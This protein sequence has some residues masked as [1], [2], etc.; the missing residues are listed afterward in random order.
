MTE[1]HRQMSV[2]MMPDYRVDNPYQT[3]LADSL[4]KQLISVDFCHGYRR[5]FPIY[6]Q[7][8]I[9]RESVLH[10]HW[11]NPYL[12][13]ENV[14]VKLIYCLKFLVDIAL[15]KA[16]KT[17]IV[18]TVHNLVSHNAKFPRLEK[19]TK[20]FFLKSVDHVI[21][22]SEAAKESVVQAYE[23]NDEKISVVPH[24]HYRDVY[25]PAIAQAEA[26]EQ[27]GLSPNGLLFLNFGMLRPY[28]GVEKLLEIWCS[29]HQLLAEA[30]LL[31]AG[32]ALDSDYG[33]ELAEQAACAKNIRLNDEFVDNEKIHLYFSAADI[34]AL[35]FNQILTSGSLLLAMSYGKPIIAPRS[36]SIEETLRG[37]TD[38]LYSPEDSS[39]LLR[40]IQDSIG[41]DLALL[42]Q[43]V[44]IACDRLNWQDIAS[45]TKA[46]YRPE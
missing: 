7:W 2:L 23:L 24:G 37:A 20:Q 30:Q 11:L 26:R 15:I 41:R 42:S 19:W 29:Q 27:L 25:L 46:I 10:L 14:L 40:V 3:L 38:F 18:W 33:K 6:R 22:H 44:S 31:I 45:A 35:P 8:R 12:K 9:D 5:V 43:N 1:S 16:S 17:K 28:K 32:K 36:P 4:E 39:G 34:V 13:G 21:V